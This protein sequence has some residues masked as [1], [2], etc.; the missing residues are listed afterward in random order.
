MSVGLA[1]S[2]LFGGCC[3]NVLSLEELVGDSAVD[4]GNVVTFTQFVFVTLVQLPNFIDITRNFRILKRATIPL[5][6][7]LLST[8]LFFIGSTL[9]NGV[10]MY[11]VSIPLH[12]IIK[13]T[14]TATTMAL[15]SLFMNKKYS[16]MQVFSAFLMTIGAILTSLFREVDFTLGYMAIDVDSLVPSRKSAMGI[17]LLFLSTVIMSGLSIYNEYVF[18]KYGG[19]WDETLFY[20]HLFA[21]PL[22]L[23]RNLS[24]RSDFTQMWYASRMIKI[25]LTSY[26][27]PDKLLMLLLNNITQYFCIKSV[28]V[29]S[30][31][32]DA[33]TLSVILL[34]RKFA[35]LL[36]S[37]YIYGNK[38]SRTATIGTIFVFAGATMY[39]VST[40]S[41]SGSKPTVATFKLK[42]KKD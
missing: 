18:Q 34:I 4:L 30:A 20:C 29:L 16:R 8:M 2:F 24:L 12:I 25:P 40:V 17:F 6:I 1:I 39:T 31:L 9:N 26:Q 7:H 3:S 11:G 33:L 36:L 41:S 23:L 19:S 13:C 14:S 35:S 15:S 10:F 22:F 32:T 27:I 37:I 21:L 5:R 38:M 42:S 28:N